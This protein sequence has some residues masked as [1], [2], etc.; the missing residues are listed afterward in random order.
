MGA[1]VSHLLYSVNRWEKVEEMKELLQSGHTLVV[2]RYAYSGIAYSVAK[3]SIPLA[4]ACHPD[5]GLPAPDVI[6]YFSLNFDEMKRREGFGDEIFDTKEFQTTVQEIYAHLRDS[7]KELH[8]WRTIEA[9]RTIDAI[10]QQIVSIVED[11]INNAA[12][13][14]LSYIEAP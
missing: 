6:L 3:K 14:P 1:V 4:W 13:S 11:V 5:V 12:T 9:N 7:D 2:D 8:R 10:H